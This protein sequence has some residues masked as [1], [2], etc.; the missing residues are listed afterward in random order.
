MEKYGKKPIWARI[1]DSMT[2]NIQKKEFRTICISKGLRKQ[3]RNE[4]ML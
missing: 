1:R 3:L 2:L 4:G